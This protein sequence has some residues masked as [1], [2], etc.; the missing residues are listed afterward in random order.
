M[1]MP[2]DEGAIFIAEAAGKGLFCIRKTNVRTI[3]H[4][5]VKRILMEFSKLP[6]QCIEGSIN[7]GTG[8]HEEY[9]EKYKLL[10]KDFYLKF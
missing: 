3:P 9:S 1:I 2:N 4:A 7:I 6:A 5:P 8:K 10:T